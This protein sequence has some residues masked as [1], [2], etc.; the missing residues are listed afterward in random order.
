MAKC[1]LVLA[2]MPSM[3]PIVLYEV[4]GDPLASTRF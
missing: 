1:M 2:S 4:Q 3:D